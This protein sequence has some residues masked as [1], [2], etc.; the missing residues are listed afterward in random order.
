V[1]AF[2]RHLPAEFRNRGPQWVTL[3]N[4]H[5]RQMLKGKID[6]QVPNPTYTGIAA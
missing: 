1:D 6:W 5:G 4:G 2:T 3:E